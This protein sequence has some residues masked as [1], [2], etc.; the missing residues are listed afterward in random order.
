M[1]TINI[2]DNLIIRLRIFIYTC[3]KKKK[4]CKYNE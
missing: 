1:P 3:S 2:N 4:K